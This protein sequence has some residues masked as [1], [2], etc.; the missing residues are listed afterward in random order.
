MTKEEKHLMKSKWVKVAHG[1]GSWNRPECLVGKW[2]RLSHT[3]VT[4]QTVPDEKRPT[5]HMSNLR[6][7]GSE[8]ARHEHQGLL[9]LRGGL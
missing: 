1:P 6:S 3:N 2:P 5:R 9:V 7:D 4:P 8:K